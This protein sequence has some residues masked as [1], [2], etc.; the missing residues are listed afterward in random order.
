[1]WANKM[2]LRRI[3]FNP[4]GETS[5]AL[6]LHVYWALCWEESNRASKG[7]AFAVKVSHIAQLAG[8]RYRITHKALKDL[9]ALGVVEIERTSGEARRPSHFR[10]VPCRTNKKKHEEKGA[11]KGQN[12]EPR[13]ERQF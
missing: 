9:E 1:M 4:D 5:N 2:A 3:M 12:D 10:L 8:Y 6:A 7:E 13:K 11:Q